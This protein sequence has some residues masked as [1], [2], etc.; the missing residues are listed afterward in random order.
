[1]GEER[2]IP[3]LSRT[4]IRAAT[5]LPFFLGQALAADWPMFRGGPERTGYTA[6][7]AAPPLVKSWEFQAPGGIV[8]SP[9]VYDG[10][11]Y[12]GTRANKFYALDAATGAKLWERLTAGWVDS[13]PAVSGNAVYAACQGGRLYAMDRI[14]GDML[15]VADLG[16]ASA[17]SPLV[18]GGRVYVGTGSPENKLKVYDAATGAL[19][20]SYQAAQPVDS[21]PS[22]DG[23]YVYFGAND[24]QVYALGALTL[25]PRWA[26][27]PTLGAFVHNAVAVSSGALYFLPGRDEKKASALDAATRSPLAVSPDLARTDPLPGAQS[28]PWMQAGSP[29]VDPGGFVYFTAG[30]AHAAEASAQLAALSSGTL[31]M[32]WPSSASL[33]G[34]SEVGMLASPAV[35]NEV[36]YAAT[37]G[38]RLIAVSASGDPLADLDLEGPAYASPAV[39]NGM[40]IA[41]NYAGKVFGFRAG[42]RSAISEPV[43]GAV[44][45]GTVTVKGWFGNPALAG[46]ELERSTGGALPQWTRISSSAVATPLDGG[47]LTDW[48]VSDLENGEYLL[49]LRVLESAASGYDSSAVARVRVN[50]APL[51]P[52]GLLAADVPGD[53]GNAVTLSW[54]ASPTAGVNGYRIYRNDG[55]GYA[56]LVSTPG[57]S[58]TDGYAVTG[59]TYAYAVSAHDGWAESPV[60][61]EVEVFSV[62]DSGDGVPPSAVQ[63]LLVEAGSVGGSVL[64]SWTGSGDDADSGAASYYLIRFSTDPAQDWGAFSSLAGSSMPA[65]GLA[66]ITESEEVGGLLGGVT[67]YFSLKAVDDAGN[68]A[69]LSNV[70]STSAARDLYP[71][72]PPSGLSIADAPGDEGGALDLAWAL[73]P[74]D[75]AGAADVY[76]YHVFRRLLGGDYVST[77][78]YASVGRGVSAY[79]D[80]A[81]VMNVRY[82]YSVAAFDST[83]DSA[84]AGEAS[85]V[86]ADNWRFFDSSG[87]GV[88]RL[89]D[90]MEVLVPAASATQNDK[91]MVTRL[92]PATYEPLARVSA[93]GSANPTSIVYEV[94]FQNPATRLL[95]PAV[96]NLPYTEAEVAG[97]EAANLRI[98]TLK[99]GAWVMLNTSRVDTA[100]GKVSAEVSSFSIFR[101]MEYL[102]SGAL[103]ADG[104]VYTYPNPAAGDTV[105]FKFRPAYKAYVKVAVYN[106]AGEQVA[107]LEKADCPAGQT[108]EIVWNVKRIASGV[109]IFRLE[110]SSSA[111]NKTVT[112]KFAIAH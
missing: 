96:I 76:G 24:G 62:N 36:V 25:V 70:A 52:T 12:F 102:P 89:V 11:V 39:S 72:L 82:Y 69:A 5:L 101:V 6:E 17:S 46:Y 22:T 100:A 64:L 26:A 79:R 31:S 85:G 55:F 49:R 54:T 3:F 58:Y 78:P 98:Y 90:G 27:Y 75:G 32:V 71:P 110:A 106:V 80:P 19:L 35:A 34:V 63:D 65:G 43:S 83:N 109:Y 33:E 37:P 1:M 66:G 59:V 105:T 8:S 29:A 93:A 112:K 23:S 2:T 13:S 47:V 92:D 81:T 95:A 7:Q 57:L 10:R 53:S 97:M 88:V 60:C 68:T 15:W 104:E 21:A 94:K 30:S 91:I 103:L 44:L 48:D 61:A 50:A 16:A 73:S 51:P 107:S 14:T 84:L 20:G 67:Y 77:A 99:A 74:D 4:A 111:G 42:R 87:G 45:S 38:G 108:S 18:L 56:L 86:S 40:V 9:A 28:V 41:A